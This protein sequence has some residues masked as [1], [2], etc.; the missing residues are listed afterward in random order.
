MKK[1]MSILGSVALVCLVLTNC[2]SQD[3]KSVV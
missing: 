2:S 1:L 3:R